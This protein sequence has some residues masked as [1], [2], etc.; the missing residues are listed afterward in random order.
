MTVG[1]PTLERVLKNQ[2]GSDVIIRIPPGKIKPTP[3]PVLRHRQH[4][5]APLLDQ[6]S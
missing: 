1:G 5:K 4:R 6:P 3:T 2:L